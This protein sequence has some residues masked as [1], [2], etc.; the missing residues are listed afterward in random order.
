MNV[1]NNPS[2][3]T[4][5]IWGGIMVVGLFIIFLPGIIGLDGFDGG[6]ALSILGGFIAMMAII[7]MVIYLQMAGILDRITKKENV[8]VY[9]QYTPEEWKVY[10]EQEHE[11]DAAARR[12]LFFMVV[13]IA[14]IVGIVFMI[15]KRENYFLI[16]CII[17]GIIAITGIAAWS[18]TMANYMNNKRRLGEVYIALDGAYLNRQ[19]HIWKGIGNKLEAIAFEEDEHERP[20]IKID[21]S[22]PGRNSRNF[23]TVRIP[24]PP[25]Q[26][27]LAQR[28]VADI[29]AAHLLKQ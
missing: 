28:V 3:R 18:S 16:A 21:Y 19:V 20:R 26:E 13:V 4:A 23:Y 22:S 9:W 25:G 17:L 11:E 14:F 10:T 5:L 7:A 6:F 8:L 24:V 27:E 15:I 2:R 1:K 29:T 12:N